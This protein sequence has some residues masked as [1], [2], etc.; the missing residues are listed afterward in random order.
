VGTNQPAVGNVEL[1]KTRNAYIVDFCEESKQHVGIWGNGLQIYSIK[2][3]LYGAK[4]SASCSGYF[5]NPFNVVGW[6]SIVGMG[7]SEDRN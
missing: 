6:A 2:S 7:V 3:V 1:L 5:I 4:G